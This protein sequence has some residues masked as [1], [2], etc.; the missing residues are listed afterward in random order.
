MRAAEASLITRISLHEDEDAP[1]NRPEPA[2]QQD[3]LC[4]YQTSH[5]GC[6]GTIGEVLPRTIHAVSSCT[7]HVLGQFWA[8]LIAPARDA[9][10]D[11]ADDDG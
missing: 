2:W 3:D 8:S 4:Q 1:P 7:A 11:H 6:S 10:L 5:I 9:Y